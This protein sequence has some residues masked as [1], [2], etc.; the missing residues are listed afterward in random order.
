M[1]TRR[2]IL[3]G[4]GALVLAG[5]GYRA[6]DRGVFSAGT[7]PAYAPW[8]VWQGDGANG[9][10]RPLHAAILAANPHD[11]QPWLFAAKDNAITVFADRSRNLGTMDPFRREMHLGLGCAVE[12]IVVAARAFGLDAMVTSAG[13]TLSRSPGNDVMT[14]AQIALRP[15][16]MRPDALYHAI[17]HRHTNRGAYLPDHALPAEQLMRFARMISDDSVK[18]VFVSDRAAHADLGALMVEATQHIIADSQM[19][20]D[21]ARWF[22]TGR[23]DIEARRDGVTMDTA[24]LS[25]AMLLAAKLLPDFDARTTDQGWLSMTR[26]M[27]IPSAPVLGIVFVRDRFDM[28]QAIGAGRAW[29]RL[30][31]AATAAGLAAQP[32]NQPVEMADRNRMLG[33][34]DSFAPALS[35]FAGARGWDATFSFRMGYAERDAGPSPRRPLA[36]VMKA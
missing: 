15:A 33:R 17:P 16:A 36:D 25:P 20:A 7:G 6:W 18:V 1:R 26:D 13:G 27:Q 10:R 2:T 30:H 8:T 31:L 9:A 19:S 12:N 23:R 32:I 34:P 5:L 35:K 22:R 21:S 29:Q 3:S 24:G 28:A 11:T 4:A 14:A